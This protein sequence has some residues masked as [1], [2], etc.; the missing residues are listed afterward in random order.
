MHLSLKFPFMKVNELF[1]MYFRL[2]N[3]RLCKNLIRPIES[4]KLHEKGSM[5]EMVTY[6]YYVGRLNSF[7]DQ[8]RSADINLDYA[9]K[10][11]HKDALNNKKRILKYLIPVKL[12]RGILPTTLCELLFRQMNNF[13]KLFT[14]M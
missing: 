14:L 6:R 13:V 12:Y 9:F 10:H 4:R 11:C 8:H 3:L 7:E 2:N 1:G 5:A